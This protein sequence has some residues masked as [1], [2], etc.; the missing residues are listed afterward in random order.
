MTA[1]SD[2]ILLDTKP[3]SVEED[4]IPQVNKL[5]EQHPLVNTSGGKCRS[6]KKQ[7][8]K[9]TSNR[10]Q[11]KE[12]VV[13]VIM[14]SRIDDTDRENLI[15]IV[16]QIGGV[17][18]DSPRHC[19]HLVMDQLNRTDKFLQC[20]PLVSFVLKS[21]WLIES[22]IAGMWI[23]EEGYMISNPEM[24]V[25]FGFNL[26]GTLA[27]KNRDKLF[28]GKTFYLTPNVKPGIKVLT[29]MVELSGGR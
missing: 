7:K 2:A 26:A 17:I 13:P 4:S 29:N 11:D 19:T 23:D 21:D 5:C 20:L 18:S 22:G 24:E 8:T 15:K 28:V 10:N 25:K 12:S 27:R 3:E 9:I 6:P 14:I 16:V 1:D